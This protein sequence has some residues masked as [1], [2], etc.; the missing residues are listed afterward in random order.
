MMIVTGRPKAACG[1]IT[2]SG[3]SS[4]PSSRSRMN[5]GRIAT[6]NG[7]ISPIV[8]SVNSSSLPRKANRAK[9][10][11]ASAEAPTTSS[12]VATAMSVLLPSCRQNDAGDQDVGV[13]RR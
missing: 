12:V 13:V 5:S 4:R 7:N 6:A 2:P 8:K 10:N 3:L 9:T 11:A 1:R